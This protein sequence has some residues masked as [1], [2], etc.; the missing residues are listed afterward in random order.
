MDSKIA[1]VSYGG[2]HINIVLPIVKRCRDAGFDVDL[3]ALTGANPHAKRLG[4]KTLGYADLISAQDRKKIT[5]L[6]KV[7]IDQ[8][9]NPT[10]GITIDETLCYL[11]AN[12]SENI[13]RYGIN[14]AQDLYNKIGRHSFLP[15][16]FFESVL[17]QKNYDLV[18]T[19][20]SPKSER[21]ALIAANKLRIPSIRIED[22]FFDDNLQQE[23]IDKLGDL[24]SASIGRFY[25]APTKICVM[26]EFAKSFYNC[27]KNKMLLNSHP[28]DVIVTGQPILDRLAKFELRDT[29][30][31]STT[32]SPDKIRITWFHQNNT[33]DEDDVLSLLTSWLNSK[34]SMHL[35]LVVKFH[36]D[37]SP[38]QKT[39]VTR[40]LF[41]DKH[42]IT[43]AADDINIYE[44]ISKS[45]VIMAQES[46]TMLEAFFIGKSTICLDPTN[47][48]K[49]IPYVSSGA[50]KRVTNAE[51][52]DSKIRECLIVGPENMKTIKRKM[53]FKVNATEN[54]FNI[55]RSA[56]SA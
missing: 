32:P 28:D 12:W 42:S 7:L 20:N 31:I 51:E 34:A 18:V 24:Y 14:L 56:L 36:P 3:I 35:R 5:D 8:N 9:F 17:S 43:I 33:P 10:S 48:R 15:I 4:F 54:I 13:A 38:Q 39:K 29:T 2:G 21:A 49:N 37:V 50:S 30:L 6:G 11:G 1:F 47:I 26:S 53:G 27:K 55:I 45:D 23:L 25:S 40:H 52:L 16:T 41:N 46:T 19:T 22:L 44:L